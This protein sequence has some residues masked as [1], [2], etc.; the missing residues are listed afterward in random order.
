MASL[1]PTPSVPETSTGSSMS[2]RAA[3]LK[4]EPKPPS[5][6]MTSGRLVAAT[7]SLIAST[8]RAP[9]AVSTPASS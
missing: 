8:A 9:S 1:V 6:P 5:P 4:Q 2:L 3:A 7:A